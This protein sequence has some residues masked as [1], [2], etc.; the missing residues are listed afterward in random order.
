MFSDGQ[1]DA[2]IVVFVLH[3]FLTE[4]VASTTSRVETS[5]PDGHEPVGD[6]DAQIPKSRVFVT[7]STIEDWLWR[8]DDPV[9]KDMSLQIYSMW[10]Y[11]VERPP[12]AKDPHVY[13][14][15]RHIE[16]DFSS[17]YKLSCSHLQRISSELRV[18][19]FQCYI[20]APSDQD[21]ELSCL[22]KQLLIRPIAIPIDERPE[23]IRLVV[24]FAPLSAPQESSVVD[25]IC[26]SKDKWAAEAFHKS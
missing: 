24:S 7:T 10:V 21:R 17:D 16:I 12:P 2:R 15:L 6:E 4:T 9:V 3:R 26:I 1:K 25:V 14:R 18:P 5:H 11:K 20:M 22:Y 23:D 19:L 13:I 8:G